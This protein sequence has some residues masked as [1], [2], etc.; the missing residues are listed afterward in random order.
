[1][2]GSCH[3]FFLL[4]SLNFFLYY[5]LVMLQRLVDMKTKAFSRCAGIFVS[6][7]SCAFFFLYVWRHDF[8]S[9]LHRKPTGVSGFV[10]NDHD[11]GVDGRAVIE[12]PSGRRPPS[13]D[14]IDLT[15]ED[16]SPRRPYN[17]YPVYNG[18]SWSQR[19]Y[20]WYGSRQPCLGPRGVNVNSNPDDMLEAWVVDPTGRRLVS[21]CSRTRTYRWQ[22]SESRTHVWLLCREWT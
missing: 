3:V 9:P 19:W 10:P 16:L 13:V 20:W 18:Q 2:P 15:S 4:L 1:M 22:S 21:S 6:L 17:V 5:H 11:A 12:G 7:L 14:Y 8:G